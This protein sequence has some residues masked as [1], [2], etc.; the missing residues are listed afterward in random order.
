LVELED[1]GIKFHTA[2]KFDP[3]EAR[4]IETEVSAIERRATRLVAVGLARLQDQVIAHRQALTLENFVPSKFTSQAA[5]SALVLEISATTAD[6]EE[7]LE[8]AYQAQY[9]S[10]FPYYSVGAV[11]LNEVFQ[12]IVAL[13]AGALLGGIF[14]Y[15]A[16]QS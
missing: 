13:V 9:P 6:Y 2:S 14:V 11:S 7:A 10:R 12:T 4:A 3:L 1:R 15:L 16:L 5:N 8:A